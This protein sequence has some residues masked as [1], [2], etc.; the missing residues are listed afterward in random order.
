MNCGACS[1][2]SDSGLHTYRPFSR[3]NSPALL[4]LVQTNKNMRLAA[5]SVEI[6][7]RLQG[8]RRGE[9][10][11]ASPLRLRHRSV[12]VSPEMATAVSKL[13]RCECM[14]RNEQMI[15]GSIASPQYQRVQSAVDAAASVRRQR[16]P[17]DPYHFLPFNA[18]MS[19]V[20][21]VV[22]D[23]DYPRG[24]YVQSI[25]RVLESAAN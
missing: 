9:T 12:V 15:V 7:G 4:T 23:D 20:H 1:R 17:W 3:P 11:L 8:A 24:Q 16:S 19:R 5:K 6:I 14:R 18:A 25:C 21:T 13:H 10:L 2:W 22:G